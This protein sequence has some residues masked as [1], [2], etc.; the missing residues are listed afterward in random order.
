MEY[1][2]EFHKDYQ[3]ILDFLIRFLFSFRALI[4]EPLSLIKKA[5]LG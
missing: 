3:A 4:S 5:K 2:G 1:C